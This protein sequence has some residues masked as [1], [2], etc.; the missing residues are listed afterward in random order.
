MNQKI[1]A[2]ERLL[3]KGAVYVTLDP[4]SEEA[5]VPEWFKNQPQ[6]AVLVG[7]GLKPPIADFDYNEGAVS[8]WLSFGRTPFY[9]VIPWTTVYGV[10]AYSDHRGVIWPECVPLE[11]QREVERFQQQNEKPKLRLVR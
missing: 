5:V 10:F 1:D 7:H 6:L 8:G 4:R 9:C 11:M 2:F 3:S